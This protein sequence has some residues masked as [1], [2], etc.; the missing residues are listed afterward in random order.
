M[1]K[2]SLLTM[3]SALGL[4]AVIGAGATL[5]YL[6]SNT[7]T[8]NNT[9]TVG[10]GIEIKLDEE[11]VTNP[12]VR[13]TTGNEYTDLQPG[14]QMKKDPT[15]TVVKDSTDCYVFMKV[16][17]IDALEALNTGKAGQHD[18]TVGTISSA[19]AKVANA[20]GTTANLEGTRDGIYQYIGTTDHIVKKAATDTELPALFTTVTY[21]TTA[22]GTGSNLPQINVQSCAVQSANTSDAE[23][24]AATVW[25][26]N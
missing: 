7:Q 15:T 17:G 24:L 22:D 9:F 10:N 12:D 1:K 3:I 25:G 21:N 14:D 5:A 4:I 13:T 18:F 23:A 6:T 20:D 8:L 2:K 19:W 16:T 11:D 26:N